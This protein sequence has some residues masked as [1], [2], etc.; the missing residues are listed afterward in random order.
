V[1]GPH[2]EVGEGGRRL[3]ELKGK[4]GKAKL[5]AGRYRATIT[6]TAPGAAKASA[7]KTVRFTI[8]T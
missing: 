2:Q 8:R 5:P 7:A 6:A 3:A 1:I 4:L